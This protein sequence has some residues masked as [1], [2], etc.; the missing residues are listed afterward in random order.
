MKRILFVSAVLAVLAGCSS[1]PTDDYSRRVRDERD[2]KEKAMNTILD[3]TP[4]WCKK[5]KAGPD[6]IYACGEGEGFT[7]AHT[8]N[9][10]NLD[11]EA[12][13]CM[14]AGGTVTQQ[15]KTFHSETSTGNAEQSTRAIQSNCDGVDITGR[16]IRE[17][18][19]I[20]A[21]GKWYSFVEIA[22]PIGDANQLKKAKTNEKF[23][24]DTDRRAKEEFSEMNKRGE[25]SE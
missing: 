16:E 25:K 21:G 19:T 7:K 2:Q 11:A 6:A 12:K 18:K 13:I 8:E 17:T 15:S 20:V 3:K 23:L 10:A 24:R 22:L 4:D 14:A 5:A 1:T 9:K